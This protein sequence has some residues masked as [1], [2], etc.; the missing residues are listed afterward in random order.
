MEVDYNVHTFHAIAVSVKHILIQTHTH[1]RSGQIKYNINAR[2]VKERK[3]RRCAHFGLVCDL[4]TAWNADCFQIKYVCVGRLLSIERNKHAYR[5]RH[6]LTAET[7]PHQEFFGLLHI[8]I[9]AALAFASKKAL[10][11]QR[12]ICSLWVKHANVAAIRSTS[13]TFS[14]SVLLPVCVCVFNWE[15]E[16]FH[17]N[18]KTPKHMSNEWV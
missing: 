7:M 10:I 3:K 12:F 11:D 1:S 13:T 8:H 15:C 5:R 18:N 4:W 9:H 2:M 17:S 6:S 14:H 16:C